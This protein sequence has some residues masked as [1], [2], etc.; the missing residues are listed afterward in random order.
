[1]KLLFWSFL[2]LLWGTSLQGAILIGTL[3]SS[4]T[5]AACGP[6]GCGPRAEDLLACHMF[7]FVFFCAPLYVFLHCQSEVCKRAGQVMTGAGSLLL[8]GVI[9]YELFT[10]LP[11]VDSSMYG[12]LPQRLLYSIATFVELPILQL[13]SFG[14]LCLIISSRNSEVKPEM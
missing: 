5:H 6:W 11:S 4:W 9:L 7:W 10:W 13:L 2:L 1:M 3:S 14:I 12:Y 8:A